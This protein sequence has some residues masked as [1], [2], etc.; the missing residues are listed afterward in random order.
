MPKVSEADLKEMQERMR[1]AALAAS[2]KARA[3][4]FGATIEGVTVPGVTRA[5]A[6]PSRRRKMNKLEAAYALELEARKRAGEFRD[7]RYEAVTLLLGD[8][9]RLT[10]DF[11]CPPY[12][13]KPQ[14]HEVKGPHAWE[15]SIVKI[16]VAATMYPEFD[17]FLVRREG[18]TGP[19]VAKQIRRAD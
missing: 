10:V 12:E 15:D 6:A 5:A 1:A 17:F 16:R 18:R 2:D 8:D 9:A 19:F 3:V 7:V 13:G 4:S 14:L 11:W